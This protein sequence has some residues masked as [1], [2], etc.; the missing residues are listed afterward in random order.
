MDL[1]H[2]TKIS[3]VKIIS[4]FFLIIAIH[5]SFGQMNVF[6]ETAPWCEGCK[7]LEKDFEA[8]GVIYIKLNPINDSKMPEYRTLYEFMDGLQR[9]IPKTFLDTNN[10]FIFEFDE[11][12]AIGSVMGEGLYEI[13]N[14]HHVT[15]SKKDYTHFTSLGK[16]FFDKF[17]ENK[18]NETLKNYN[19]N[20]DSILIEQVKYHVFIEKHPNTFR[21][22][23]DAIEP[24]VLITYTFDICK[25]RNG[26]FNYSFER[27]LIPRSVRK[28]PAENESDSSHI[29]PPGPILDANIPQGVFNHFCDYLTE[30]CK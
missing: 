4:T 6:I 30:K 19:P 2:Q 11:P 9:T 25:E 13:L 23:Y 18:F 3:M 28:N 12:Y 17:R 24:A 20:C 7:R 26:S 29:S 22:K 27:R 14:D 5:I 10:N 15:I 16:M 1:K 8:H 21:A